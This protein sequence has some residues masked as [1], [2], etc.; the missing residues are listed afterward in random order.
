MSQPVSFYIQQAANC[1]SA[2][3]AS[4]LI[5]ER[6]KYLQAQAAWQ[7][8]ADATAKTRDEAAKRDAERAKV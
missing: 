3:A 8:L 5:N 1:G 7:A 6:D 2:A 4:T